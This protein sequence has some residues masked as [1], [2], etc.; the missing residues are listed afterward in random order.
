[1]ARGAAGSAARERGRAWVAFCIALI[2]AACRPEEPAL[3]WPPFLVTTI[4]DSLTEGTDSAVPY[5]DLLAERLGPMYSVHNAGIGGTTTSDWS[6][7]SWPAWGGGFPGIDLFGGG[8]IAGPWPGATIDIAPLPGGHVATLMLGGN[9]SVGFFDEAAVDAERYRDQMAEILVSLLSLYQRVV[10]MTAPVPFVWDEMP[11]AL[12]FSEY[13]VQVHLLCTAFERVDCGPDLFEEMGAADY[14]DDPLDVHPSQAGHER[15]SRLLAPSVRRA[16][17]TAIVSS[18][19][20]PAVGPAVAFPSH[21]STMEGMSPTPPGRWTARCRKGGALALAAGALLA[22]GCEI[23]DTELDWPPFRATTLG[24]SITQGVGNVRPYPD[25][26][27]EALGPMYVI[28]NAGISGTTSTDWAPGSWHLGFLPGVDLFAGF[29]GFFEP[30][31]GG[32]IVTVMLGTN[33]ALGFFDPGPVSPEAYADQLADLSAG[34]LGL[35]ARVVLMTAPRPPVLSTQALIERFT[36]YAVQVH[37]LCTAF[38]R[39]VCGPDLSH[40]RVVLVDE[41]VPRH[42]LAMD[43]G[44]RS[45]AERE[46][47]TG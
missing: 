27:R 21:R 25:A 15:I 46:G 32:H 36:G 18:I 40:H 24:D 13:A 14:A 5:P 20:P 11:W 22:S 47:V 30:L 17:R 3:D 44:K 26:L 2:S 43:T 19:A 16:V 33:D 1:M 29:P 12:R 35:Y 37:L 41:I 39:I 7:W 4:G 31:P 9:D 6:P 23:R 34:L 38:E 8:R 28:H 45:V 42:A 10:L